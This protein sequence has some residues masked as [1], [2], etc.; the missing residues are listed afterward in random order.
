MKATWLETTKLALI[1]NIIMT[2]L[3]VPVLNLA[4]SLIY[5]NRKIRPRDTIV[6]LIVFMAVYAIPAIASSTITEIIMHD[7]M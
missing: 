6:V 1:V 5:I 7:S 4:V 3:V 2:I